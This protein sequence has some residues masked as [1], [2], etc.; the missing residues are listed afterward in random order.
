MGGHDRDRHRD[1]TRR[2]GGTGPS[3]GN[4]IEVGLMHNIITHRPNRSFLYWA[5]QTFYIY[6]N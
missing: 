4:V 2:A 5:M 1:W 3:I 6:E